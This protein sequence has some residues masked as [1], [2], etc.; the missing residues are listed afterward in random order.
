MLFGL[1]EKQVEKPVK[2][3]DKPAEG[4]G[5]EKY[6]ALATKLETAHSKSLKTLETHYRVVDFLWEKGIEIYDY[7]HVEK[8]LEQMGRRMGKSLCWRGLRDK[9]GHYSGWHNY[10]RAVPV[11]ILQNVDLL[12]NQFPTTELI[13]MVS[14]FEVPNPDP[15][16]TVQI[17]RNGQKIVFGVWDEPGYSIEKTY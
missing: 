6:A 3:A 4:A 17:G 13:F 2:I 1:F 14:D 11:E 5:Y 16:I 7:D 10:D 9:D 8:Y 15:F 12:M